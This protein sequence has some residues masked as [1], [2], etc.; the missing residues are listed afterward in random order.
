MPVV[1]KCLL[2]KVKLMRY[3]ETVTSY[4]SPVTGNG[5]I[6]HLVTGNWQTGNSLY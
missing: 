1:E 2:F 6:R 3:K 5:F 4:Q